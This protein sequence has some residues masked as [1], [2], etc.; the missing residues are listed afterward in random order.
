MLSSVE[1]ALFIFWFSLVIL[2][3]GYVI[4]PVFMIM[5]S[6]LVPEKRYKTGRLPSVSII[7]PAYNEEEVIR[8]KI[9]NTLSLDYP[10]EKVEIIIVSDASEDGTDDIVKE[11]VSDRLILVRQE[12][13]QGKLEALNRG[14]GV[15]SGEVLVFTDANTI[16]E[17][18]ALEKL[19]LPFVDPRVGAV[20]GEQIISKE[21]GAA[22]GEGLYWRLEGKLKEAES[23]LGSV[24]GADGS[25]YSIRKELYPNFRAKA[26][27]MDD[28]IISTSVITRGYKLEYAPDA[29]SYE[30][31]SKNMWIEFRR[32]ARIFAGSAGSISLVLKLLLKPFVFKLILHKFIR[33]FSPFLLITLFISNIFLISYGLFYK[34][35]FVAQ[36]IFYGLSIIGL[37]IE[38]S[39]MPHSR[40]TYFPL[41]FTMTNVAEVYGLIGMIAGRYKPAWKKLR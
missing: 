2:L 28:F 18:D 35:I 6:H 36:C 13:R 27:V 32:K 33:W 15:A 39:G 1:P 4:Y 34:A 26:I 22:K 11:Y 19:V 23:R 38:L 10:E 21:G 29:H 7:I 24:I 31:A 9:D 41:Y 3:M 12:E 37:A 25:M 20:A 30:G 40:L 8:R 16:V 17:R 14:A 5:V